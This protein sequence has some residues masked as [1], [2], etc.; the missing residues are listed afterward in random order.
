MSTSGNFQQNREVRVKH[1]QSDTSKKHFPDKQV[2]DNIEETLFP[3]GMV[4]DLQHNIENSS[5][6]SYIG[7]L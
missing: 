1:T 4:A 2:S 3:T 5:F 6:R 7:R